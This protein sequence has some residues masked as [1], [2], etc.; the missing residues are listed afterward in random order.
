MHHFE[1]SL[2]ITNVNP[3]GFGLIE[4]IYSFEV[5]P[6]LMSFGVGVYLQKNIV[7]ILVYFYGEVY[8]SALELSLEI[9]TILSLGYLLFF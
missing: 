1:P 6:T 2:D 4:S 5:E 3:D 7:L 8:V 9:E